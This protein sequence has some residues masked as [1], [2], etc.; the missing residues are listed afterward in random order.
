M[1]GIL[2]GALRA[3]LQALGAA[4]IAYLVAHG[5][6]VPA[7]VQTWVTSVL[8]VGAAGLVYTTAV[9]LLESRKGDSPLA[10]L[11]RGLARVLMLGLTGRQPVYVE[12]DQ[13][14]R[15][16]GADGSLRPPR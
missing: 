15:V 10:R 2:Y 3:G 5:I 6:E 16:M 14:L 4:L 7:D 8:A 1:S 13:R 12:P 9:R 11:A